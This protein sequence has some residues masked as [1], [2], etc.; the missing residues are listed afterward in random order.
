MTDSTLGKELLGRLICAK[1]ILRRGV[2][3][4]RRGGPFS[5]GLAVL[6]FQDSAEMLLR[7]IAEHL[8]CSIKE[9]AAFNQIMDAIDSAGEKKLTHRSALNQI[10]RARVN[11]KHFGLEPKEEDSTKFREDLE[12]FFPITI[13]SF[14]DIEFESVSMTSLVQHRRTENFLNKAEKL[15]VD[16]SY[17]EAIRDVAIAFAVFRS[18]HNTEEREKLRG[19]FDRFKDRDI[20]T[21]A[22]NVE[23]A[24]AAQQEQLTI[25]ME[26]INLSDYRRFQRYLP[27]V[28]LTL[29]GTYQVVYTRH[30]ER[31]ELSRDTA[32]FCHQFAIEAILLMKSNHLP[33][34]HTSHIRDEVSRQLQTVR[35]CAVIVWPSEDPEVIRLAEK[36]EILEGQVRRHDRYNKSDYV[37]IIQDGDTAYIEKDGVISLD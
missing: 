1:Y 19:S 30:I 32:L 17:E 2:E 27:I 23:S 22:K 4:L 34:Q 25:I 29:A 5:S 12:V 31:S 33:P 21:W 20:E 26:G 8:D 37:A 10:N 13:S 24:I 36:G 9:N 16:G 6:H 28:N 14:L 18:H 3:T 7:V 11:F 35:K 15:I